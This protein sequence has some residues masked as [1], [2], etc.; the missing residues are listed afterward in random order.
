MVKRV[1]AGAVKAA[2]VCGVV[3]LG[4]MGTIRMTNAAPVSE[5]ENVVFSAAEDYVNIRDGAGTE[6]TVIGKFYHNSIGEIVGQEGDWY[7]IVSGDVSGFVRSDYVVTGLE[8]QE[9]ASEAL[10]T[11]VVVDTEALYLRQEPGLEAAV[12]DIAAEGEQ[13]SVLEETQEWV[14]V[15]VNGQEGYFYREHVEEESD[16]REAV[17]LEE[18]TGNLHTQVGEEIAGYALQFV[19]NPYVWG[20]TSLT[21]GADCSGFVQAVFGDF[22]YGLPRT[23]REQAAGG[24]STTQEAVQ[25]GDLVFYARDGTVNHVAI[26]IGNGQVVHASNEQNGIKV[27]D[28]NYRTVARI[29]RYS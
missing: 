23:S 13:Y 6:C 9:V 25:P 11:Y 24:T 18:D 15:A 4:F 7:Q 16:Y 19:G 22:G 20:G 29:V 26:Y 21:D 17:S 14:K 3:L 8:A 27:S 2:G 28:V 10:N 5:Y 1:A 12:L